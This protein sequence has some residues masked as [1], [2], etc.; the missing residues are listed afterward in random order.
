MLQRDA[1]GRVQLLGIV[2]VPN[3]P[4]AED[5]R[6]STGYA[7]DIVGTR[8]QTDY[9]RPSGNV[10]EAAWK[11]ELRN[12]GNSAVTVQ[13]VEQLS[14][15]WSIVESSERWEKLSAGAVRFR[16]DVAAGGVSVLEYRVS[17]RT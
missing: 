2:A 16:V 9:K 13:V 17:V 7:F 6:L 10:Y 3:T 15:D 1:E 12:R 5:L 8:T 11:V 14:G 4:I